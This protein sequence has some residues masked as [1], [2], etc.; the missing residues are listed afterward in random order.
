MLIHFMSRITSVSY[1]H[2]DVYKRQI[3]NGIT[4]PKLIEASRNK[5]TP[6]GGRTILSV[7]NLIDLKGI[8]YNLRAVAKLVEKYPDLRYICLL[9]TS[10]LW[11]GKYFIVAVTVICAL[12]GYFL[13]TPRYNAEAVINLTPF[14]NTVDDYMKMIDFSGITAEVSAKTGADNLDLEWEDLTV[15]GSRSTQKLLGIKA[16]HELLDVSKEAV[17]TAAVLVFR[18]ILQNQKEFLVEEKG[19]LTRNLE[20]IDAEFVDKYGTEILNG[21]AEEN[22]V[23]KVFME[24]KGNLLVQICLLYTSR[25][26]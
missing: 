16:S 22:P 17:E 18:A 4:V 5:K 8:D 10:V 19:S 13:F 14:E 21:N 23:Y 20:Y 3:H 26:V 1:T 24:E 25:C 7:S 11:R 6:A 2:L 15:I 12:I 9:Y